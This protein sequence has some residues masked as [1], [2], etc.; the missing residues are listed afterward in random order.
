[1]HQEP[2]QERVCEQKISRVHTTNQTTTGCFHDP[3][4]LSVPLHM[5]ADVLSPDIG[6]FEDGGHLSEKILKSCRGLEITL[7]QTKDGSID[8]TFQYFLLGHPQTVLVG[9]FLRLDK[10]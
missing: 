7:H 3:L 6:I 1:M 4:S 9:Q 5:F 2:P 8:D 10:V